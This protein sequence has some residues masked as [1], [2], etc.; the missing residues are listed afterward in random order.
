MTL[1]KQ[2]RIGQP[3]QLLTIGRRGGALLLILFIAW[4]CAGMKTPP[5]ADA[6]LD[7]RAPTSCKSGGVR[8]LVHEE[9]AIAIATRRAAELIDWV[10]TATVSTTLEECEWV[11]TLAR[12]PATFGGS[13]IVVIDAMTG[14]IIS[15]TRTQ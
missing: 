10:E 12:T 14:S 4:G 9:E 6:P 8:A 7:T 5:S 11:V 1:V 2:R 13:L 15:V 3:K